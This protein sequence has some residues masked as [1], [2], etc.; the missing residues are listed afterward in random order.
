MKK[1]EKAGEKD[2]F[3][4]RQKNPEHALP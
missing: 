3:Q 4:A 1:G 2:T